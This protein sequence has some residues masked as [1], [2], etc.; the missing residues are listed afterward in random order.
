MKREEE[1]ERERPYLFTLSSR[2][3][4]KLNKGGNPRSGLMTDSKFNKNGR[5]KIV[6][7]FSPG[8]E[9]QCARRTRNREINHCALIDSCL[10]SDQN[11]EFL[12]KCS[13]CFY[14]CDIFSGVKCPDP[15][16]PTNGDRVGDRFFYK[17]QVFYS[18]DRLFVLVGDRSQ[19][20]Q[21]N[22]SWSGTRPTCSR[23]CVAMA[24]EILSFKLAS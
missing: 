14:L 8:P 4:E 23:K 22:G 6:F 15:G 9:N 11:S 13:L 10:P 19:D 2:R 5:D 16:E 20:C 12:K 18:C 3:R 1:E 7:F 17:D 24:F 21:A